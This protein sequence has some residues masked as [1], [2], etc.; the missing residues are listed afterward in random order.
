MTPPPFYLI[1]LFPVLWLAVATLLGLLSGWYFL[2]KRYPDRLQ[3]PYLTLRWQSGSMGAAVGMRNVLVLSAC[4]SGLRVGMFRIFGPFCRSFF[5]PWNEIRIRR[6]TVLFTK[7]ATLRFG[8]VPL[9]SLR[10]WASVADQ[11]ARASQG[12]WPELP[13]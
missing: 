9:G 3:T 12:K 1:A 2:M 13:G 5:V 6:S 4:P 10:I 7:M 8:D 11:L